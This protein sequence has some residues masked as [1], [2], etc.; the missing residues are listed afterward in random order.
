MYYGF[1]LKYIKM[2]DYLLILST[3]LLYFSPYIENQQDMD[4]NPFLKI[5]FLF[6]KE[7]DQSYWFGTAKG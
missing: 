1:K 4:K 3:L 5:S 2:W 6:P 7:V